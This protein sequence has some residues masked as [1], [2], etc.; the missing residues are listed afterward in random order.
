MSRI[1]ALCQ[2]NQIFAFKEYI[3]TNKLLN[4]VISP[5]FKPSNAMEPKQSAAEQNFVKPP[6]VVTPGNVS[7]PSPFTTF[8]AGNPIFESSIF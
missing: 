1:S 5:C 6:S 2:K 4:A 3:N 8:L 7:N